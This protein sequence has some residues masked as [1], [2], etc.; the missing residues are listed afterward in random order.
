MGRE[1]G[2]LLIRKGIISGFFHNW[3]PRKKGIQQVSLDQEKNLSQPKK[4]DAGK[5][6]LKEEGVSSISIPLRK[7]GKNLSP[8]LSRPRLPRTGGGKRGRGQFS[9][10]CREKKK[11]I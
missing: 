8:F 6:S 10:S 3:D 9:A 2:A 5:V 7:K 1:D 4:G 11:A